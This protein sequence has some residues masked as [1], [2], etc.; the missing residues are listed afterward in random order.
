MLS[1]ASND[2][3]SG[4][5]ACSGQTAL[6]ICM[7][8]DHTRAHCRCDIFALKGIGYKRNTGHHQYKKCRPFLRTRAL[9]HNQIALSPRRLPHPCKSCQQW[10]LLLKRQP[11]RQGTPT[12]GK[13]VRALAC[14]RAVV[15]GALSLS[16]GSSGE[17]A[18]GALQSY[19]CM[20]QRGQQSKG[21]V[22]AGVTWLQKLRTFRKPIRHPLRSGTKRIHP[23]QQKQARCQKQ[24][25]IRQQPKNKQCKTLSTRYGSAS[26]INKVTRCSANEPYVRAK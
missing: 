18:E 12:A 9:P 2:N 8:Y 4:W 14:V 6:G 17:A 26:T 25:C 10:Q 23:P 3:S 5:A 16:G 24:T 11:L 13:G 21:S 19:R 22:G 20:Q 1:P 7:Q 15:V